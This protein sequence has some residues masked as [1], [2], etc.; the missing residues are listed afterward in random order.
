MRRSNNAQPANP[1]A[2]LPDVLPNVELHHGA[3]LWVLTR[4]GFRGD[5]SESTFNEYIKSL[6]KLGIPFGRG[7]LRLTHRRLANY[8]YVHLMELALIMT[9]RVYHVVP[10]S[11]LTQIIR[12]RSAL[13]RHYRTAYCER[14]SG[15]GTPICITTKGSKGIAVRGVF[16]DLQMGFSGGKLLKFGPPRALS[17]FEAVAIFAARELAAGSFL[18][19]NLSLLAERLVASA[20][21]AP[22]IRRGPRASSVIADPQSRRS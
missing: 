21:E 9:L 20:L 10:D 6:R 22:L 8:S 14:S 12:Y 4:L 13:C 2:N 16:L 15:I 5:V 1:E 19:F 18:P 11:V 7:A 3:A 17:P